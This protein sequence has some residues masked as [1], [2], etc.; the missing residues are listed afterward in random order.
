[1][2]IKDWTELARIQGELEGSAKAVEMMKGDIDWKNLV[3]SLR[4]MSKTLEEIRQGVTPEEL[5]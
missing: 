1:M 5:K 4:E 3:I 2:K